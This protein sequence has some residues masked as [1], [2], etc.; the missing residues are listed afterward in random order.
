MADYLVIK[1]AD[2]ALNPPIPDITAAAAALNAQ[3]TTLTQPVAAVSVATVHG[4]LLLSPTGD[5]LRVEARAALA[6]SSGYP[7]SPVASDAPIAAAK[8]AV[9]LSTSKVDSVDPLHWAGF[10]AQLNILVSAGDISTTSLTEI[11][12]L[13]P[14]TVA[15]WQPSLTAGDIQT[16]RMQ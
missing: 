7:T 3:T 2:A 14:L 13:A 8:L 16:A 10:L 4:I 11:E 9:I 12:S 6:F 1:A 15:M 5:W